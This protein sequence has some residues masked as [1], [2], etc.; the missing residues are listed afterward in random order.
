MDGFSLNS[1]FAL[2]FPTFKT[3]DEWIDLKGT[4]GKPDGARQA[5]EILQDGNDIGCK[6][7][8][9]DDEDIIR[10]FKY[11]IDNIP[12]NKIVELMPLL[13]DS[14]QEKPMGTFY[15]SNDS[16]CEMELLV[17]I[18]TNYP[19]YSPQV[20]SLLSSGNFLVRW[21]ALNIL[22]LAEI[23]TD[24]LCKKVNALSATEQNKK[25][26]NAMPEI[27]T[28]Y[29]QVNELYNNYLGELKY[30]VDFLNK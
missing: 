5:N 27:K 8:N 20:D 26:V 2:V 25:V 10:F 9:I 29:Y 16:G 14:V 17:I 23:K 7:T 15:D 12:E 24:A 6:E 28:T 18:L 30:M 21:A 22:D 13:I 11:N 19:K 4:S 3:G 1:I